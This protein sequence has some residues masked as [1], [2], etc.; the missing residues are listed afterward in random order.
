MFPKLY[1]Y[2][3]QYLKVTIKDGEIFT[4]F[5]AG[6]ESIED[7]DDGIDSITLIHTKQ[8]GDSLLD[9]LQMK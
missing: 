8:F 4:G 7:S 3:D 9:F 6:Y 1:N 2:L 5:C